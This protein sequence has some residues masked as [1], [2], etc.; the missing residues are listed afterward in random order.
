MR[1]PLSARPD[2]S[3]RL[4][5]DG[6]R[7]RS[8]PAKIPDDSSESTAGPGAD[9]DRV[10]ATVCLF[11]QLAPGD[12]VVVLGIRRVLELLQHAGMRNRLRELTRFLDRA[13]DSV[14]LRRDQFGVTR[15][16]QFAVG[17]VDR[18]GAAHAVPGHV[19]DADAQL[20]F[21]GWLGLDIA[22]LLEAIIEENPEMFEGMEM[23]SMEISGFDP[24]MFSDPSAFEQYATITRTDEAR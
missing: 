17:V 2:R 23:F 11:P 7:L 3:L 13:T 24:S 16:E 6:E 9:D 10:D 20:P 14:V 8:A 21:Q 18:T 19:E 12:V 22:S 1:R 5:D 15:M 4:D